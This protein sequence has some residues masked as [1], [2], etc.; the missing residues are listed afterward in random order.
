[1]STPATRR[2]WVL[3]VNG[4]QIGLWPYTGL[5]SLR[6]PLNVPDDLKEYLGRTARAWMVETAAEMHKMKGNQC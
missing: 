3:V 4:V 1:M 6:F 5:V 2:V